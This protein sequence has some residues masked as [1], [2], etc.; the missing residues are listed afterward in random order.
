MG[1]RRRGVLARSGDALGRWLERESGDFQPYTPSDFQTLCATLRVGDV[2]LVEGRA[3]IST[4]IKYLTQSTW[5]HA[6]LYVG[7]MLPPRPDGGEPD[8]L[9]EVTLEHGC[10][11]A[12][13]SK[14][15]RH[16]TRICRAASLDDAGRREV[17]RFMIDRIGI[18]Y[19]R[20]NIIDLARFLVPTPPVPIRWRRRMIALGSGSPTRAICSSLIAEAF[21]AVRY[22]ILPEIRRQRPGA[23]TRFARREVWH[24]RHHSLYTPRD[25]DLSPYFAVIKPLV[26]QGFDHGRIQWAE[27][28]EE[29]RRG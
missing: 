23:S 29:A 11:A 28:E 22:P 12:P 15:A 16:N 24:I 17:A 19:D 21:N 3:Q 26:A 2:L 13:L 4:A 14:Y 1:D 5:S 7:D 25:F 10:A 6:A 9:V 20:R 8:R 27:A 18:G